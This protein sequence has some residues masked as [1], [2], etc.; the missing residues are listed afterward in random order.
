RD[1][2]GAVGVAV[3]ETGAGIELLNYFNKLQ[4]F[5]ILGGVSLIG[6]GLGWLIGATLRSMGVEL[7]AG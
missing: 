2:T 1:A 5:L 6:L 4:T 3:A 7:P